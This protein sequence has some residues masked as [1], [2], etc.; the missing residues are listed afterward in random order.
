MFALLPLL[1]QCHLSQFDMRCRL[2]DTLVEPVL[3][4][5]SH[6]WG[7]DMFDKWLEPSGS[8]W[9]PAD[10]VHFMF[11][12]YCVGVGKHIHREVLLREFHRLPMCYRWLLLATNWWEKASGNA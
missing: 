9:S 12:R 7:P 5:G 10:G 8:Q 11:L 3:S 6:V 4:Y 2:F 1:R